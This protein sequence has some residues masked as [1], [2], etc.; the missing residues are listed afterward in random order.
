MVEGAE[1]RGERG[2]EGRH[3]SAHFYAYNGMVALLDPKWLQGAFSTLVGLLDRVGVR[4]IVGKTVGM[5][6]CPCQAAG[7][8]LE[9]VCVQ[10]MTGEGPSYWE[11]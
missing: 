3:H 2:Q 8:Q 1:D 9:A 10:L 6:C 4:N 5:V 7:T 11:R